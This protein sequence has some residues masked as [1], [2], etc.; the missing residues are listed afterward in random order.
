MLDLNQS[1]VSER[2]DCPADGMAVDAEAARE[3]L[4]RRQSAAVE[5]ILLQIAAEAFGDLP[6]ARNPLG[7]LKKSRGRGATSRA[8]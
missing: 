5:A 2:R 8:R 1:L 4:F 6:P 7:K 3:S